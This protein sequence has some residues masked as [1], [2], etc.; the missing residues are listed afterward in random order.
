VT[1]ASRPLPGI[2]FEA[3]APPPLA[4]LPRM[5]MA[6]FVGFAASGPIDVPVGVQDAAQFEAIFGHDA[7]LYWDER[8]G[9]DVRAFLAPAVRAFFRN[10]GRRCFVV[11]VA[12]PAARAASFVAPG[13]VARRPGGELHVPLLRARSEGSWSDDLRVACALV[14]TPVATTA[15]DPAT[16]TLE[17]PARSPVALRPGDLVRVSLPRFGYVAYVAVQSVDAV[18]VRC[19][20][21]T[22]LWLERRRLRQT[23]RGTAS[24]LDA[25]GTRR[26]GNVRLRRDAS[27]AT[28]DL[29]HVV[30]SARS[31]DVPAPGT[32]LQARVGDEELWVAVGST[33][34]DR[35]ASD[36]GDA[37]VELTG[38][39]FWPVPP[40]ERT[41]GVDPFASVDELTFELWTQQ[42]SP[43]GV[44]LGGLGFAPGHPRYAG[45]L[46]T[47]SQ[48][49]EG[50]ATAP[51]QSI[52]PPLW[53][54][55][56]DP[57]FPLAGP[58]EPGA[59]L[60]PLG[61]GALPEHSLGALRA[62]EPALER[63]GL[64]VFGPE[65]FLD[66]RLAD[67]GVEAL[68]A[69]AEFLRVGDE[70]PPRGIHAALGVADATIVAAPDAAQRPWSF[71]EPATARKPRRRHP[72]RRRPNFETCG[73]L[74]QPNLDATVPDETGSFALDW[75]GIRT[76]A[77]YVLQE[78]RDPEF[79][80][81]T[82][83]YRG[84][85]EH[86]DIFGR[87]LGAW[88]YRVRAE[89]P[90]EVGPWS[91]PVIVEI[92]PNPGWRSADDEAYRDTTLVAVQAALLRSAAARGDLFTL[93]SLPHH[94]R[95]GLAIAHARR[96]RVALGAGEQRALG[97]GAL[98]HPWPTTTETNDP[99]SFRSIP[100]DGTIAGV[101]ARR[102]LD[103]GAWV[104]PANES[105]RDV[106]ALEPLLERAALP[107]LQEAQ[108]NVLRREPHGFVVLSA[109]TL[110][111]DVDVRPINVRRLLALLRRAALLHGTRYVFESND[112]ALH[113]RIQ[114]GFEEL[115]G[116][117]FRLG[118]FAGATASQAFRV[119]VGEPPNSPQ[120]AREGRL[121]VELKVAPSLPLR[122]LTVRL[123]EHAD[124]LLLEQV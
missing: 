101:L 80:D 50:R 105:L 32:L 34:L 5:D 72:H 53:L 65:L 100:P 62:D 15:I 2:R 21:T 58:A 118:A 123:V 64:A 109:D 83:L 49:Y 61:M 106:I 114:R 73:R 20:P 19:D 82:E 26:T 3:E 39:A 25:R 99:T 52:P 28:G 55:A 60:Y 1:V 78:A 104:A 16:W 47:D 11:R 87:G 63:D 76:P 89:R 98:Y 108:L 17:L 113:R 9:G 44:R 86:V 81:V 7:T 4:V 33:N 41:F 97:Y 56:A 115:L 120:S 84:P 90:G 10:G 95:D 23:L 36:H 22:A 54:A 27:S 18:V 59:I 71:V 42:R 96:L 112:D 51:I 91:T 103:R 68:G 40:P 24:F 111:D 119:E 94:Y 110:S 46:P 92:T 69:Q 85:Q 43:G 117:M 77:R 75:E 66:A 102:A 107:S 122:F 30:L 31:A 45:D 70:P 37:E 116:L 93:I 79:G 14:E 57:R 8:T 67:T 88:Y 35:A 124:Q 121:I 38:T 48:L 6:L 29:V 13:L 74:R 12:G